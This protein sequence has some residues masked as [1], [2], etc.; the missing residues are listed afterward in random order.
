MVQNPLER[1]GEKFQCRL[2]EMIAV[3]EEANAV[4]DEIASCPRALI[5]VGSNQSDAVA[6]PDPFKD[7]GELRPERLGGYAR[8]G[9]RLDAKCDLTAQDGR[10][11]E[12]GLG[13]WPNH[14]H[15]AMTEL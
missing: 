9:A 4:L 11:V 12:V 7:C 13:D 8:R 2:S 3:R 6:V 5:E 14:D 10:D 1:R 15:A